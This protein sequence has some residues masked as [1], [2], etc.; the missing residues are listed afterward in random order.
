L[1]VETAF[2]M[3]FPL[4]VAS[5]GERRCKAY[6]AGNWTQRTTPTHLLR[7]SGSA[8]VLSRGWLLESMAQANIEVAVDI[9]MAT[10]RPS[11]SNPSASL[12][13]LS[14]YLNVK[15]TLMTLEFTYRFQEILIDSCI[16]KRLQ[17]SPIECGLSCSWTAT[18]E[19]NI[20]LV[21]FHKRFGY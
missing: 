17:M 9:P 21:L 13:H 15:I 8:F 19:D 16:S 12:M 2:R 5:K 18:K 3:C 14:R 6:E 20:K 1:R 11:S 4:G 7:T 10:D